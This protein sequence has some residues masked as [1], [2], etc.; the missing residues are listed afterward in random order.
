MCCGEGA[1]RAARVMHD[2]ADRLRALGDD[3][4]FGDGPWR[5]GG[6]GDAA[7]VVAVVRRLVGGDGAG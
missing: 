2:A 5:G 6:G 1:V 3:E 7:R 4:R